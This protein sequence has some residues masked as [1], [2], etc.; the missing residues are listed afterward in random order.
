[1]LPTL[2]MISR[3]ANGQPFTTQGFVEALEAR[4][5]VFTPECVNSAL[6]AE[7]QSG[8]VELVPRRPGFWRVSVA[9]L[10]PG[11]PTIVVDTRRVQD[12]VWIGLCL[13][14][15]KGRAD[16]RLVYPGGG[17]SPPRDVLPRWMQ[18]R[19]LPVLRLVREVLNELE[20]RQSP[21]SAIVM[22]A[23]RALRPELESMLH[24]AVATGVVTAY[25]SDGTDL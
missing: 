7:L 19:R 14:A 5:Y 9:R 24:N 11:A 25:R 21:P 8:A 20:G 6:Q 12:G 15:K 3:V 1:M 2:E 17:Q 16:V 4:G 18:M 23:A 10:D 22:P 13:L